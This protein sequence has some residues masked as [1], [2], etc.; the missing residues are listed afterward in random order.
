[1]DYDCRV[2][3]TMFFD[4]GATVVAWDSVNYG[5]KD[6]PDDLDLDKVIDFPDDGGIWEY[7][8]ASTGRKFVLWFWSYEASTALDG[9]RNGNHH[10]CGMYEMTRPG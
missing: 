3:D 9:T 1:M 2:V 7:K 4:R 6:L 8:S 10:F 5:W